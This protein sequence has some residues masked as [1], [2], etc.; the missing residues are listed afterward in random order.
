[1]CGWI[2]PGRRNNPSMISRGEFAQVAVPRIILDLL[3]RAS[4]PASL[5]SP[6]SPR[7]P[8]PI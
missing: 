6:A 5:R 4:V 2:F 1:M 8:I 3:A 7:S